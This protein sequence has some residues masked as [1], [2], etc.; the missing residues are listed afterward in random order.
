MVSISY[1][2]A[3][4]CP[5]CDVI[6]SSKHSGCPVCCNKSGVSM[7]CIRNNVVKQLGDL[8]ERRGEVRSSN[9]NQ[10]SLF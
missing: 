7:N 8:Q 6:Y 10:L 5:E 2:Q 1:N 3:L 4:Y 9:Y